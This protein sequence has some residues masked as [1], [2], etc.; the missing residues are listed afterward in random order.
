MTAAL[1]RPETHWL[2]LV[3]RSVAVYVFLMVALRSAGR[4]ELGQMTTFDM[5][6]LLVLANAVQNSINAGD[7]SLTSGLISAATL[8]ATNFAVGEATYRWRWFERLV[9][10]RPCPLVRNGKI[11]LRNMKRERITLEDLRS[12]LRKQGIDGVSAC[13]HAQLESNGTLTAVRHDVEQH[14]LDDL[15]ERSGD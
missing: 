12:A 15:I 1:L 11:I 9:Q 8:L 14:S 2:L 13:K 3:L 6:V 4:R 5:V 10:G 7:N